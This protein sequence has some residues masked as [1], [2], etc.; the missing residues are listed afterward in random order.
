M[1]KAIKTVVGSVI[2]GLV[3][4]GPAQAGLLGHMVTVDGRYGNYLPGDYTATAGTKTVTSAIEYPVYSLMG[5][6]AGFDLGDHQIRVLYPF[7]L[8][9]PFSSLN[10]FNGFTFSFSGVTLRGA[11]IDKASM[12]APVG[13]SLTANTV[14]LNYAGV[15]VPMQSA[16]IIDLTFAGGSTVPEPASW[17]LFITGFGLTGAA[18]RRRRANVF[19]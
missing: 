11:S 16:S 13:I 2:A 9:G 10:S 1:M 17:A 4:A 6:G 3:L 19:A 18:L 7:D 5:W 8:D 12:F 14:T 15:F